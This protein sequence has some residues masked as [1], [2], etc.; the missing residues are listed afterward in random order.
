M[1][2][3]LINYI[4]LTV[5]KCSGSRMKYDHFITSVLKECYKTTIIDRNDARYWL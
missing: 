5:A 1:T 3:K 4:L 2:L